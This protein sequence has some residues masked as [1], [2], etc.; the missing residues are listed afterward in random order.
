MKRNL[1]FA[2][3]R[4]AQTQINGN[5][6]VGRD[7]PPSPCPFTRASRP[8]DLQQSGTTAKPKR[9]KKRFAHADLNTIA[10]WLFLIAVAIASLLAAF[11]LWAKLHP[12]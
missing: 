12:H 4:P 6:F 9:Q 1:H 10:I 11:Q 5:G 7:P 8:A 3:T 2:L